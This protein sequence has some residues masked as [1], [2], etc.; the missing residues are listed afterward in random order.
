[1]TQDFITKILTTFVVLDKKT[2]G[3]LIEIRTQVFF[4]SVFEFSQLLEVNTVCTSK[5][6]YMLPK[7]ASTGLERTAEPS[8]CQESLDHM[9]P[10]LCLIRIWQF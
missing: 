1:M 2:L 6:L 9:G 8:K 3:G 5:Q 10:K 7:Y 4:G